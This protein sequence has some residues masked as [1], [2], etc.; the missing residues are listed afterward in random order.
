MHSELSPSAGCTLPERHTIAN[1]MSGFFF[2]R[3]NRL[4]KRPYPIYCRIKTSIRV[5]YTSLENCPAAPTGIG[6]RLLIASEGIVRCYLFYGAFQPMVVN[7]V[8]SIILLVRMGIRNLDLD[9]YHQ[10]S[11]DLILHRGQLRVVRRTF[12]GG[13]VGGVFGRLGLWFLERD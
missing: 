11:V 13:V 7:I 8:H 3:H 6:G 5:H 2:R 1:I 12:Q 9:L 10:V 4:L